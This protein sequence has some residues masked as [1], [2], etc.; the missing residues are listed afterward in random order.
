MDL[1]EKIGPIVGLVAFV[2]L[3]VLA[4][5]LFQQSRDLRRLREWAGRAP[6]R[7]G[8][9]ADASLAASE[10]RGEEAEAEGPGPL[11]RAWGAVTGWVTPRYERFDRSL[12]VDGRIIFGA[13]AAALVAAGVLTSGFGLLGEEEG[14]GGGNRAAVKEQEEE[15]PK[16]A[17]LNAT[18]TDEVTGVP[19]LADKVADEV[20]K[21]L[22]YPLGA[23]GNAPT[24]LA[25][26]IVMFEPDSEGAAAELA[27]AASKQLGE[28]E[29][30][31]IAADVRAAAGDAPLVLVVGADDAQF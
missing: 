29:T 1:I 12:P 26:T 17:I 10:L 4:F 2:G 8:E 5:L 18:Q 6:E 28:T 23:R 16:V 3:A 22:G 9:A 31:E 7:A 19:G 14:G 20:V 24:G 21:Q 27:R 11:S 15:K 13:L 30:Q 25:E